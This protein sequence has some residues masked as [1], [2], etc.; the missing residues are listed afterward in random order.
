MRVKCD[1]DSLGI[2]WMGKVPVNW[3][4]D[5]VKRHYDIRLG[6][7]LQNVPAT[8]DDTLAPYIKAVN[9]AW[10]K[11]FHDD[12]SEMWASLSEMRQYEVKDGDL[13]V[14]EGG[15]VGRAGI[16][17]K[18][19]DCCIIQNAVHR[20][21]SKASADVNFLKYVMHAVNSAGWFEVLCN[22]AT[23]AHF[24][25]EKFAELRIPTPHIELQ[26][27]IA[28]FLDR[29]TSRIDSLIAK[30]ERQIELLQEKRV[31]LISHAVT[32]GLDLMCR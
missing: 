13:L 14:C 8:E 1:H 7:M 16:V 26:R 12:L 22:K 6:K 31:A 21:R 17:V 30:K 28:A 29:E 9:V 18:P 15:E 24:T 5:A 27:S 20:V 25:R 32:K 2:K 10:G 4:V 11:V 3:R 19:P 23:I